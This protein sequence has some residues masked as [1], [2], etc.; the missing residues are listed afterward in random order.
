MLWANG[1]IS[2]A[3]KFVTRTWVCS[4]HTERWM[5]RKFVLTFG[6][7]GSN[8]TLVYSSTKIVKCMLRL[9]RYFWATRARN[10]WWLRMS[11]LAN[12]K[13]GQ[14]SLI[15]TLVTGILQKE[16]QNK[17]YISYHF[18]QNFL[19]IIKTRIFLKLIQTVLYSRTP[20]HFF[21][22]QP[23]DPASSLQR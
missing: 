10:H 20:Q 8:S 15:Q 19:P 22:L 7:K 17:I 9:T 18:A 5:M 21:A 11:I 14:G 12:K 6:K 3:A 1:Y 23:T 16:H 4:F 2:A 13:V